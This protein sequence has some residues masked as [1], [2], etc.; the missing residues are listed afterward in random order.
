MND[1][2]ITPLTFLSIQYSTIEYR[3]GGNFPLTGL[4]CSGFVQIVLK[5]LGLLDSSVDHT[6]QMIYNALLKNEKCFSSK[7][8][9]NTI[10][11]FGKSVDQITHVAI[12]ISDIWM[13]EARGGD[14][15]C[16][17]RDASIAKNAFIETT[18]IDHRKDL[19]S[20]ISVEY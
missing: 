2:K 16:I 5:K 1:I 18:R 19:V 10:L 6:A 3:W 8:N 11:F 12:G 13:I 17:N 15:T 4:D 14:S 20:C 7:P 9:F